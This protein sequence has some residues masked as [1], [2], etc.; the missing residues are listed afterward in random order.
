MNKNGYCYDNPITMFV[1]LQEKLEYY[2]DVEGIK[3][4]IETMLGAMQEIMIVDD[5]E[6]ED[7]K[8]FLGEELATALKLIPKTYDYEIEK[9]KKVSK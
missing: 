8:E 5:Y 9:A 7:W 2:K 3:E 6:Y 1:A 4:A